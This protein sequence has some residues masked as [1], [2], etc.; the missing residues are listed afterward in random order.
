MLD[1]KK[2][3]SKY[4]KHDLKIK[5]PND[6]L[7]KQYKI[8]GILQETIFYKNLKYLLVGVGL[9]L[10]KSPKFKNYKTTSV[11]EITKKKVN[12]IRILNEIKLNYES[13]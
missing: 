10:L 11:Y 5:R 6:I 3:L 13:I 2:S 7:F 1:N 9:N 12:K 4:I 8:C